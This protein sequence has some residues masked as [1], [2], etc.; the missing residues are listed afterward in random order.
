MFQLAQPRAAQPKVV[1]NTDSAVSRSPNC[2]PTKHRPHFGLVPSLSHR[3]Q[4][5]GQK[6]HLRLCTQHLCR[7]H[8]TK[9]KFISKFMHRLISWF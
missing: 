3:H 8:K 7:V 6:I 1:L 2:V 9:L 4:Q 5:R